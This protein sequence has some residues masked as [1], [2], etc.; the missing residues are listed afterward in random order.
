MEAPQGAKAEVNQP[1]ASQ[2]VGQVLEVI[3]EISQQ[4]TEE[5]A[6]VIETS[7]ETSKESPE[8]SQ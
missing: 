6:G 1:A 4:T 7:E 3:N 8:L 5:E 2:G